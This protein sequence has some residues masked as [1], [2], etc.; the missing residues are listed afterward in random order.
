[1]HRRVVL[2]VLAALALA[3]CD[4]SGDDATTDAAPRPAPPPAEQPLERCPP[5]GPAAVDPRTGRTLCGKEAR[6]FIREEQRRRRRAVGPSK[7]LLRRGRRIV[8]AD[9]VLSEI[10]RG[11][12]HR[13]DKIGGWSAGERGGGLLGAGGEI[14]IALPIEVSAVLPYVCA[15]DPRKGSG[16]R[17]VRVRNV[18]RLHFLA[19]FS[20]NR[21]VQISP[22]GLPGGPQPQGG[23]GELL[24][25]S[26]RCPPSQ[27]D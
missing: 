19:Q 12:T 15:G 22:S 10:L 6:D 27:G 5:P 26:D 4:G 24:P 25:G 2:A 7:A 3:G 8:A 9:P 20:T 14:Q 13:I 23:R 11:H 1:M 21:V 16:R 17:R 18:T